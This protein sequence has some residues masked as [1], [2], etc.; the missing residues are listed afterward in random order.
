[1]NTDYTLSCDVAIV[2][3]GP[4]GALLANLLGQQGWSVTCLEA[5][6]DIYYSPKAVHFDD[7]AMRIFQAA[8]LSEAIGATAES[9]TDM[10]LLLKADR[11]PVV[12]LE[13]GNQDR[14]YG[15]AGAWWFHQPTLERKLRAG[16]ARFPS[17]RTQL[18]AEVT[19]V[20]TRGDEVLVKARGRDGRE[21][22]VH[23]RWVIGCDGGRSTVRREAHLELLS[24]DFDE[25]WVVVDTK[26]RTGAK[27]P[28]LPARHR[29]VCDPAQPV[30]YVPLAGPYYEWQFMVMGDLSERDAT[31][32]VR[33]RGQL[34][35]F[36][37]PD[38][39]EIN[40]IA[41]YRFHA[42]WAQR[43]R[44]GRVILAGDAAHQMPP[45]LGQ[46]MCSGLRDAH[47]L[48]WRLDLLL[49]DRATEEILQ[50]Y[51]DERGQHV[52]E[53]IRG[54]MFLGRLI[55]TRHPLIA[56]LR[57]QFLLR[58]V[59]RVSM[60]CR[61]LMNTANRK[62]PVTAGFFGNRRRA[63]A[64]HLMLQPYVETDSGRR[65]LLDDLIGNGFALLLRSSTSGIDARVLR[66]LQAQLSLT[67]LRVAAAV[68]PGAV[69]DC[70]GTLLRL[71]DRHHIDFVLVRPDRY[72]YDAGRAV[73]LAAI[74]H[75]LHS[76]IPGTTTRAAELAYSV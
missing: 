67:I 21:I 40:R 25:A 48:A 33:V 45:F 18:G 17:V 49:S 68:D 29:Q 35:Q 32:P 55:Q 65:V 14:R 63:L 24:A 20:I 62:R 47:A 52:Q 56:W 74:S 43:W 73:D 4:T 76:R 23:A 34:S 30:T 31:D 16:L 41:Y 53:I 51:E 42:L 37:D 72:I 44:A 54:A 57:N 5:D 60:L 11:P 8:G 70:D 75:E 12:R 64:G 19:N 26:T 58:P 66:E 22:M 50:D 38:L 2:G 15:H 27:E 59:G 46:G 3:L 13:V 9:F 7:E 71:F 69:R 10:E 6:E 28:R 1:M 61:W 39:V 36:V